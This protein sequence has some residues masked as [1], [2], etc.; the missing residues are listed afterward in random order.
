MSYHIV[1]AAK[2]VVQQLMMML[3]RASVL[4]SSLMMKARVWM[5][6]ARGRKRE[7]V[8]RESFVAV[9]CAR[10]RRD[11]L[12]HHFSH[13]AAGELMQRVYRSQAVVV[14]VPCRHPS[15]VNARLDEGQDV[16]TLSDAPLQR[17]VPVLDKNGQELD[18]NIEKKAANTCDGENTLAR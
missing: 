13:L 14:L 1:A 7:L 12:E 9:V 6:A 11:G 8:Q 15:G 3:T 16:Q 4:R 17:V 10:T 18:R 5:I 2:P